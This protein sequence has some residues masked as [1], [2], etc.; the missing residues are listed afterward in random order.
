MCMAR[1]PY[2]FYYDESFDLAQE[3][4]YM[5]GG[6]ILKGGLMLVNT[7]LYVSL[8]AALQCKE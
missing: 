5:P 8:I 2:K 7:V 1:A 4:S 6:L 3:G